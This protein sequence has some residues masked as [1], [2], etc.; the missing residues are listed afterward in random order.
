MSTLKY[1]CVVLTYDTPHR[2]TYDTL[3]LL[4]ANGYRRILVWATPLSYI[5][6]FRPLYEHRPKPLANIGPEMLCRNFCFDFVRAGNMYDG[7]EKYV[8]S[9]FLVCGAGLLPENLIRTAKIINS[10]PGFI[11]YSRGL[12]AFKWAIHEGTPIG[13]TTHYIGDEVDAG[14]VIERRKILIQKSDTFHAVAQR[15]YEAEINMLVSAL[16]RRE[17]GTVFYAGGEHV[18]HRRMPME[19]ERNLLGEFEDY[20][21]KY[22]RDAV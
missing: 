2:K 4:K 3:C 12:D 13:V 22:S 21:E 6:K 15:V 11:P 18:I 8:K 14:E 1:D 19:I 17:K 9:P 16:K 7:L 5:K 20:K 10:H